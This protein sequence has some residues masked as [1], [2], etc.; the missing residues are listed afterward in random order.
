MK[1]LALII[2]V[3]AAA[4][5]QETVR[6]FLDLASSSRLSFSY[7][8]S[9]RSSAS[10][11]TGSGKV[12]AQGDLFLME[13]DG[14]E[15]VCDGKT[16]WTV[17]RSA[18]EAVVESVSSG[19]DFSANPALFLSEASK[20]FVVKEAVRVKKGGKDLVKA[21]LESA[22][23]S[24]VRSIILFITPD[25]KLSEAEVTVSGGTVA[26]FIIGDFSSSPASEDLT[27][28][29]FDRSSLPSDAVITDLR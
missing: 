2:S 24:N 12:T 19:E 18:G 15:V 20:S 16:R 27:V 4:A 7:E 1:L 17:D 11:M 14:I 13:G 23:E 8:Y 28:F 3:L 22:V 9:A 29:T 26:T 21:V 5:P 25:L 10:T 6:D